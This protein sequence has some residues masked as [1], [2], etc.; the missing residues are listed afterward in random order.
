MIFLVTYGDA[1]T[2]LKSREVGKN[3]RRA[4]EMTIRFVRLIK[5]KQGI[6]NDNSRLGDGDGDGDG[7]AM[8][9]RRME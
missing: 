3:K 1:R 8:R 5:A 2:H 6:N 4:E 7:D 9:R